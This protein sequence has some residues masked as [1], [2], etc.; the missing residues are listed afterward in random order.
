MIINPVGL[1][2]RKLLWRG[3][4]LVS[5]DG[6]GPDGG[7]TSVLGGYWWWGRRRG[8]EREKKEEARRCQR[9]G[10]VGGLRPPK[11][12]WKH[13]WASPVLAVQGL[14]WRIKPVC[15]TN[16]VAEVLS[17]SGWTSVPHPTR[18]F[19]WPCSRSQFLFLWDGVETEAA[20]PGTVY[21]LRKIIITFKTRL[22]LLCRFLS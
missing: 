7:L 4:S 12:D 13:I 18:S 8:F 2:P 14:Q 5:I 19:T 17:K 11:A 16:L 10:T 21:F 9:E 6:K 20:E 15:S 22:W 3:W 1:W